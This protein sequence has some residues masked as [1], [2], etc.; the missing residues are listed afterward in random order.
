M[1]VWFKFAALEWWRSAKSGRD[2]LWLSLLLLLTLSLALLVWGSR[3]GLL[4][5]FMDV[6]LGYIPQVG[7]P[8]L[9]DAVKED[10]VGLDRNL[11]E[12]VKS[13][14][15]NIHPYNL[16]EGSYVSLP[17]A[18]YGSTPIWKDEYRKQEQTMQENADSLKYLPIKGWAVSENNPLWKGSQKVALPLEVMLSKPL[19]QQYFQ[20]TDYDNFLEQK[21]PHF[22]PSV[23]SNPL[24]CLANN[25]LWLEVKLKHGREL[26]PFKIHWI[27]GRI[28][29][30]VDKLAFLFPQSTLWA[31]QEASFATYLKYFPEAEGASV[32]RIKQLVL[33]QNAD[34]QTLHDNVA[35]CLLDKKRKN[36]PS[37]Q[38]NPEHILSLDWIQQCAARYQV[39][40]QEHSTTFLQ[41]VTSIKGHRFRY[42]NDYLT[43]LC[44]IEGVPCQPCQSVVVDWKKE[45][46]CGAH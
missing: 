44:E 18:S 12:H 1:A 32:N 21:L 33:H 46:A 29:T 13:M 16:I 7:I 11:L 31:L 30:V 28:S 10:S 35:T 9:V 3:E 2:F 20:C 22:T 38:I 45:A 5:R 26:L 40:L 25:I 14:G 6:S 17:G 43:V 34:N 41:M 15:I 24:A 37:L 36:T 42:D 23:S 8:I 27:E 4:N 19:F 39:S